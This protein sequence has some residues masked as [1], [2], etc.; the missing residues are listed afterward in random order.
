MPDICVA[1][2]TCDR[3]DR[4]GLLLDGLARQ[5]TGLRFHVVVVDNGTFSA[6]GVALE[7][8]AAGALT[9][10]YVRL[11][12]RG[13]AAARN[14]SLSLARESGAPWIACLD[15]DEVPDPGWLSALHAR[16]Q[17]TGADLVY[18]PVLPDFAVAPPRWAVE[19]GFFVKTG[20]VACSSNMM[21]RAASLPTD[22]RDWYQ[23]AFGAIGGEDREFLERLAREGAGVATA[24]T[25]IVREHVPAA[26]L[27]FG[28]MFQR[29][30]R[31]GYVEVQILRHAPGPPASR[32]VAATGVAARKCGYALY[33]LAASLTSRARLASAVADIGTACGIAMC[34]AGRKTRFYGV[35]D[36]AG[37]VATSSGLASERTPL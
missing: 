19:G 26:R 31:D 35:A 36:D 14:R 8:A 17:E 34:L 9:I 15:D 23:P 7:R 18:G 21:L 6:Q 33:H 37:A 1:I 12:A 28:Y 5:T 29:G 3:P 27:R 13:L 10:A 16:M 4:L 24:D 11:E 30:L 25:A 32:A 20:E 22:A 2:C